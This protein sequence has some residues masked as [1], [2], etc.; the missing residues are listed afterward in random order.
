MEDTRASVFVAVGEYCSLDYTPDCFGGSSS[1]EGR[2]IRVILQ[3]CTHPQS[4]LPFPVVDSGGKVLCRMLEEAYAKKV[5]V[6]WAE[7][8]AVAICVDC[9]THSP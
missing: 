3:A 7:D 2:L 4:L 5:P 8:D 6:W 9:A 1:T